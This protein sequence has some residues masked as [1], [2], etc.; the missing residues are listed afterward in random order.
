MT[1]LYK[2]ENGI[3]ILQT[4]DGGGIELVSYDISSKIVD[5]T[6]YIY[7][8][9]NNVP[10][11]IGQISDLSDSAGVSYGTK[12]N[13]FAQVGDFF[14]KASSDGEAFNELESKVDETI[15]ELGTLE[16]RVDNLGVE[17]NLEPLTAEVAQIR[18]TLAAYIGSGGQVNNQA[19]DEDLEN[20]IINGVPVIREKTTKAYTPET[21]SGMGRV[22]LRKNMVN[23][24]NVLTQ[25]MINQANT[26]YVIRYDFTLTGNVTV[27]ANCI[28]KFDGGSISGNGTGKNTITGTNT[29]II[30]Q[31][32]AIFNNGIIITGSWICPRIPS[33]W[34]ND[35]ISNNRL[36]QLI[37]LSSDNVDNHI[38]IKEGT[39]IVSNLQNAEAPIK[40]KSN[41]VIELL[42]SIQLTPNNFGNGYIVGFEDG[43]TNVTLK[44]NGEIVGDYLLGHTGTTGEWGYNIE[45]GDC[46]NITI[47]GL[48]LRNAW[49]DGIAVGVGYRGAP[50]NNIV[51]RGCHIHTCRRQGISVIYSDGCIIENCYIH[52]I[53]GAS[54]EC[55]IDVE[56]DSD[57][58]VRNTY[59]RN[60]TLVNKKGVA[61][62]AVADNMESINIENNTIH[63]SLH[64]GIYTSSGRNLVIQNNYIHN[65]SMDE[66]NPYDSDDGVVTS[67]VNI[68]NTDP[69]V[70][71]NGIVYYYKEIELLGNKLTLVN[72]T[73]CVLI[74]AN[75]KNIISAN[76]TD[77]YKVYIGSTTPGNYA[78]AYTIIINPVFIN[79]VSDVSPII[80]GNYCFLK[81]VNIGTK[82]YRGICSSRYS[83]ID[84]NSVNFHHY[85]SSPNNIPLIVINSRCV[86][87]NIDGILRCV[88]I[89]SEV[90]NNSISSQYFI[91][92]NSN[93]SNNTCRVGS[94]S[95]GIAI[96]V[97]GFSGRSRIFSNNIVNYYDNNCQYLITIF[98][99]AKVDIEN[100]KIGYVPSESFVLTQNDGYWEKEYTFKDNEVLDYSKT[101]DTTFIGLCRNIT[102]PV[103]RGATATLNALSLNAQYAGVTAFDTDRKKE[104]LWN[105][106]AWVNMNGTAL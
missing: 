47:D 91:L 3:W 63:F 72:T 11:Y 4:S 29:Q 24:V 37:N 46:S 82:I 56:C 59:I 28:F 90:L 77:D 73:D 33:D 39:Y 32:V 80:K 97:Q 61:V 16:D 52:N 27:P 69:Q 34:F 100:N 5:E 58:Y 78:N 7:N 26:I 30:A 12:E 36:K 65:T 102:I 89:N 50:A 20:A 53:Y 57:T 75:L 19:D 49:G 2:Q 67:D 14:V 60:N 71:I 86:N 64:Y 68:L 23:G 66:T 96:I 22:I 17:A 93:F 31:D 106:T 48:T 45:L 83:L 40:P 13:L 87:N 79:T 8:N 74:N 105:G 9:S 98:D 101:I 104:I 43:V 62:S 92:D 55:A 85:Q 25:E 44:G 38:M 94:G 21:G 76:T 42:G 35:V 18:S 54:P 84:G 99:N 1:K 103:K 6:I 10:L 88:M 15:I 95:A 81:I 51:I 70:T 41:T